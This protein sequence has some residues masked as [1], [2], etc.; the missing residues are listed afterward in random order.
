[1]SS[2]NDSPPSDGNM[3]SA[4]SLKEDKSAEKRRAIQSIMRDTTLTDLERRLRIQTL[5]DGSSNSNANASSQIARP[6]GMVSSL[7]GS[8]TGDSSSDVPMGNVASGSERRE[9]VACVHYE[10]KCNVIAPCC[11]AE[12][13]CRVCHDDDTGSSACG[14]MDRFAVKEIVCKE[15][16]TR[17]PSATNKCVN[18]ECGVTFAEYHCGKCNIWMALKRKPFHC[19]EC[20]FCRVGG[21]ENYKHC[22]ICSMCIH[23]SVY[24]TH[25][26][27]KDKYKNNCPVCREDMFSSRQSPQDLP[28]GHCIHSHCFRNL[29]SFDYRCPICKKTVVS[30]QSMS[31][32]WTARARDIELQPMPDDLKRTVNIICNDC[33]VKSENLDWHF[34]GVQCPGCSSF[35]TVVAV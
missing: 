9:V 5:M 34:L 13:G 12:F 17:Q 25:N 23:V 3:A 15:C 4:D 19:E 33:E 28:C 30:R 16:N 26:C 35:N 21:Q 11:G 31:A 7:L 1:M 24:D 8:A 2:N 32:A 18:E 6:G 29:A 27:M 22:S 10:R 20:G 14:P